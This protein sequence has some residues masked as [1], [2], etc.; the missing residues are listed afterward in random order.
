[1]RVAIEEYL[2]INFLM[3]FLFLY[4]A[5]RGT[6]F[7]SKKRL[8]C[9]SAAGSAYALLHA[10]F[11]FPA[12]VHAAAFACTAVIAFPFRERRLFFRTFFTALT[13]LFVL[14]S[15]ARL[16]ISNGGGTLL[17]GLL[18]AISGTASLIALKATFERTE[19]DQ[20]ARFRVRFRDACAEFTAIIDTG[21]L[22]KEPLSALPVLIADEEALGKS[23]MARVASESIFREAAYASVGGDGRM[24]CLRADEMMVVIS[25]KWVKTPDMWLG[26]YPGRMRGGVHA[27]A[28]PVIDTK[29]NGKR[30]R[31]EGEV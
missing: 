23:F 14:G 7:F 22:L 5:S 11:R 18:G 20:S 26:L 16:C 28:P 4:L 10:L 8:L 2:L 27:L 6:W 24:K 30:K 31:T 9:A 19:N 29:T 3:D 13:G 25:G 12:I 21:N 17:S 15:T 1:M